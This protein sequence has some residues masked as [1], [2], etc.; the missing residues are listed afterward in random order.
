M[1]VLLIC[2]TTN[3]IVNFRKGLIERLQEVGCEVGAVAFD[4]ENTEINRDEIARRGVKFF[5]VNDTGRGLN[6]FKAAS[7]K[8]RYAKIIKEFA[9]DTVFT[10]MMKPNIFGVRAARACGVTNIFSMVEGAGDVFIN[11]GLKWRL[12]RA[13]AC[14]M[15]RRSFSKAR[16]VFFLN[17]D[18]MAE[19]T[20]RK[21]VNKDKCAISDGIGVDLSRFGQKPVENA[22]RFLMIARMLKSKGVTEYCRAAREVRKSYPNA[23]FDYVGEEGTVKL[24]DIQEYIDDGSIVYHGV[25][26]DVRPYLEACGVYVLPSYREG[27]PMSVMEAEATGRAVITTSAVGCRSAVEDGVNGFTVSVGDSGA[28]AAAMMRFLEKPELV[29]AMGEASRA[30]AERRFDKDIINKKLVDAVLEEVS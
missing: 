9:P 19:F 11:N 27:M 10:F 1:K 29:A 30:L 6:P 18:D 8:R 3:Q 4:D 2:T 16:K 5:T 23:M 17:A 7:L 14:R 22:D 24:S 21:L 20:G 13:V 15:Y 12:I 28:L 26:R 25:T